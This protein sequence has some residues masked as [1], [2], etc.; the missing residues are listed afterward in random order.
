MNT[1]VL[2]TLE[3][4]K[5]RA[6][7]A[8]LLVSAQGLHQLT[9]VLPST[10]KMKIRQTFA[11]IAE[12]LAV[13]AENG[14]FQLSETA[15][16]SETLKRLELAA[17]VSARE[18]AR[19]LH[20]LRVLARVMH[21][22]ETAD[23]API[24][25]LQAL[26]DKYENLSLLI[27]VLDIFDDAGNVA[28]SASPRLLEL[29]RQS[30]Q[31]TEKIR[32][33]M[34]E[35]LSKHASD[36]SENI[37]TIRNGRQVLAVKAGSKSKVPGVVQD[38]SSSGLTLYIEPRQTL[39]LNQELAQNALEE[40]NE[41]ARI[42][43][44]LTEKIIP[45]IPAIRQNAWLLGQLDLLRAKVRFM[46]QYKA[47]LP[48]ISDAQTLILRQARHPLIAQNKAVANDILFDETLES[49][50]ITGPNTG[51]KTI[52]LKTVGLSALMAQAGLPILADDDSKVGIFTEIFAN[53][54][55]E[56]SIEAS[57]STFS[58]HMTQIIEIT[59]RAK[60]TS[61]VLLDEL[62]AGTDPKE[63]AALAISI[64]TH[65]HHKGA[66]VLATTHYPELKL[67]ALET[68]KMTNASM[69]FDIEQMRP[70]Y[71]FHLGIPGQSNAFEISR[72][73]GLPEKI[74][75]AA[76]NLLSD[77]EKDINQMIA[78]L[79]ARALELET[80]LDDTRQIQHDAQLKEAALSNQLQVLENERARILE[81]SRAEAVEIA[82]NADLQAQKIL[83]ALTE[84][85]QLKSHEIIAARKELEALVPDLS[86]N[87][88]LKKAKAQ[89]GLK[90]GAKVS[91]I[92]FGQTG[93]LM[94]LEKDGR[95]TVNMGNATMKLAETDFEALDIGAPERPAQSRA[96]SRKTSG[97]FAGQLDLRGMR[98][99]EALLELESYIDMALL[100]NMNQL[101]IVH[102]IGT[103]VIRDMVKNTL[104]KHKH[105]KSF[106]YAPLNA[107]GSG[108]T[109]AILK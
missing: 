88:V 28:D 27:K 23:N 107:G 109:I 101:T 90:P 3:F 59:K 94:R 31:L 72:R 43:E 95:W 89:R 10:D 102:G 37:I 18:F 74:T 53:I 78:G 39:A 62:G 99:D 13:I 76:E 22:F 16:I 51:G 85:S 79:E 14:D 44:Q 55:D 63:G 25:A 83:S 52:T 97:H 69:T 60:E 108:A 7:F 42:L 40:K 48:E 57:L 80:R 106:A 61:L 67:F 38:L 54:G 77:D 84:K 73:L 29:R 92:A 75:A 81:K 4:E 21:Y 103:G 50:I 9:E 34:A 86:V 33:A 70:T 30:R 8:P 100:N 105:I 98:Y 15:D 45:E 19:I 82:K 58:S 35:L 36:L 64:L 66:K 104:A 47:T 1:K 91:V 87:K 71:H 65:L 12:L 5:V 93:E 6:L 32:R 24:S 56:Q 2:E 20:L 49:I 17:A 11:Q 26:L 46:R 96:I 68:P 41:I